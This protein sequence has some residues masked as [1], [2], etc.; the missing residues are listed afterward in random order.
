MYKEGKKKKTLSTLGR[1]INTFTINFW[2]KIGH[3]ILG[4]LLKLEPFLI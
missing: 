3:N 2:H 1:T 4:K